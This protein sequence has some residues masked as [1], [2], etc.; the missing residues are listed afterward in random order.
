VRRAQHLLNSLLS[1]DTGGGIPL[2]QV[3]D[4][5]WVV[6]YEIQRLAWLPYV[7]VM[8]Y[9]HGISWGKRWRVWGMPMIQRY[10]G[11]RIELGDGLLL[12]S[13][14]IT[15]PLA[16]HHRVV[17]ATRSA[18]A[19]IRVGEDVAMSGTNIVAAERIEIGDFAMI[20]SNVVIVDTDF[21]P[22]DPGDR[23]ADVL[24]GRHSPVAIEDGVFV[25]MNSLILKGVRIGAGAVV[26]AGSVV[27]SDVPA[28]VVVAGNPAR[29]V[30][31]LDSSEEQLPATAARVRQ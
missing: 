31:C 7:R 18:Q 27:T 15:N 24:G 30:R 16:P 29:V 14:S 26:G 1:R 9:R 11:S 19:L 2:R 22:L 5:P 8:F 23:R 13:W 28:G 12:R 6:R 21:H 20:G 25:G 17:L 4:M 3:F 10:R